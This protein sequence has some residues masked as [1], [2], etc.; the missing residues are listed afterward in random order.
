MVL[1]WRRKSSLA[2]SNGTIVE[3]LLVPEAK[4]VDWGSTLP[5]AWQGCMDGR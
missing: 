4:V 3:I 2:W 5:I 1:V